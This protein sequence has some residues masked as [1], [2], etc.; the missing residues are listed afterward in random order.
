MGLTL[1]A[2]ASAAAQDG[3]VSSDQVSGDQVSGG[4][5][6]DDRA[7]DD[8]IAA[9]RALEEIVIT[10]Q[11]RQQSLQDVGL[12]I[13][14]FSGEALAEYDVE[15][16][17]DIAD[18]T[19]GVHV[20]GN[21]AGQN[22]QFTIR[23]VTQNDFNDIVESPNAVY[24]D[25][26]YIAIAQAQTFATFDI[27]R[28]E[29]LKGPQGTLFG[30]NATGG[31]VRYISR[32]PSLDGPAGYLNTTYGV[33]DAP[34]VAD[35]IELEGAVNLPLADT[36]AVRG[37]FTYS[38]Q[39]PYME[40][41]YPL[42]AVGD[43]PGPGAGA[44]LGDDDTLAGRFTLLIEPRA[45][46]RILL[47]ANAERSRLNTGP[48]Q[49]KP[50]IAVFEDVNGV[51]ELVNTIDVAP[52]ET[53]TSIA[54]DGG[55]FG[56]DLDNDGLFAAQGDPDDFFGRFG[57]GGDFF[58]FVDPDGEDF[59]FSSD[60]AFEDSNSTDTWGIN[61]DVA[62][63]LTDAI[64]L[65]WISDFKDYAKLLFIDVDA[66]PVNQSANYA[67]VDAQSISQEL[68][69]SGGTDRF[70]W[71]T[72]LYYLNIDNRS[73]NGLKFPVNSVVPGAPFDLGS[74]A[75]LETNSYSA[76][77]QVAYDATDRLTLVGGVR[78]IQEEK[79][80]RFFQAI[81]P[82]EDSRIIHQGDPQIIGP[83]FDANGAPVTFQ[84]SLSDTHWAA[85]L[86]AE[87]RLTPD[88]LLFASAKRGV[89]AGSFN[90]QLAGGLPIPDLRE[91]I[92]YDAEIL[93]AYEAGAKT[94]FWQGRGR[95]NANVFFY[96]YNDYQAFLFTGVS[97]IVTNEDATYKGADIKLDLS[98]APGWDVSVSTAL[99]DAKIKDVP[100]RIGGPISR[101][102]EP[103]YAP[104][105]QVSAMTRYQ[106]QLFG[107]T[108]S[109]MADLS[110]S[111]G[112]YYNLRNFDADQFDDYVMVN[113][114]LAWASP[115]G[116]WEAAFKVRNLTDERA[117]VQGFN[118]AGLC[119]CNEIAFRPPRWFG[120][121]VDYA[122]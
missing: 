93:Y 51:P 118:L 40:N 26:G 65:T 50:T 104:E 114:R 100:L 55:D 38:L 74:E 42:G 87:Y 102:V 62:W 72:G 5:V 117:G 97:G 101:D 103:T 9:T 53:R 106:W 120:L 111:D 29:I 34:V 92:P 44:D 58:G 16:S 31:L 7:A 75:D 35:G 63:D 71:V 36:V 37:A 64:T 28:V 78:V 60:F 2:V 99:L 52:G 33:Y 61:L 84:D 18:L 3:R 10:A 25:E 107:G 91:V 56:T 112:F 66:A 90:A 48:F 77:G 49:S 85:N 4:Q 30:R 1:W 68:R 13:E 80:Y 6:S 57:P 94:S 96:D 15:K 20:S 83:V 98:P 45:D 47:A 27:D 119:G 88:V 46:L 76:F 21:L 69:L 113:F 79:D 86:R 110:W 73:Q 109:A 41:L 115:D 32:K 8:A 39:D 122:Y 23:G 54:P 12:A 22:T 59:Q 108:A 95:F 43:P 24:L 19:P 105:Y 67:G 70:E 17:W 82:T 11:R 116:H 89:K 81:F 121:S 14:A